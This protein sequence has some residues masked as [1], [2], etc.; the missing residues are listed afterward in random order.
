MASRLLLVLLG[1]VQGLTEFLP[2]SSSGH[3]VIAQHLI[4]RFSQPGVLFDVS[5]HAGTLAAVLVYFR[6]DLAAMAGSLTGSADRAAAQMRWVLW[7]LVVGSVPTAIIGLL[8]R[9]RVEALFS[10]PLV[11]GVMLWV[12]GAILFG[13]ERLRREGRPLAAMRTADAV[14]VGFVQ[15]LAIMPGLSRSGSTIA[16]GVFVGLEREDALRYSFLLS[17]PA[18]A[19]AFALEAVVHGG[20]WRQGVDV[21]GYIAATAVAFLVGY[22]SIGVLFR[23]LRSRRL[24]LF[25][26]YC[27]VAG[28]A[29]LMV[30]FFSR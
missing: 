13:T 6:R 7:M 15:G 11:A 30:D 27:C 1:V 23:A 9:A 8:F 28:T 26:L 3:L 17:I 16:A 24:G 25:A 18:V 10:E 20:Q 22:W 5:L 12:T 21:P 29:G 2:V 4:P 14:W 19:G